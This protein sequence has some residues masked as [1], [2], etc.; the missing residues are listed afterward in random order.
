MATIRIPGTELRS[1]DVVYV[2]GRWQTLTNIRPDGP[3]HFRAD[4][5]RGGS[6]LARSGSL[7]DV[8]SDG[9]PAPQPATVAVGEDRIVTI[10]ATV[11]VPARGTVEATDEAVERLA[12]SVTALLTEQGVELVGCDWAPD[13]DTI[14]D[15]VD[16]VDPDAEDLHRVEVLDL[17]PVRA[18]AA[19]PSVNAADYY[20]WSEL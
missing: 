13:A 20:G 4:T 2:T 19:A 5:D 9:R 6:I 17:N 15:C 8:D 10:V 3:E 1:G 12:T 18:E 14:A 11:R 16:P 7:Y